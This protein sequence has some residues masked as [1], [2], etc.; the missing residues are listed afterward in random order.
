MP[1]TRSS[2]RLA[3]RTSSQNG[4]SSPPAAKSP[5]NGSTKR[6][7]DSSP[8]SAKAKKG[9]KTDEAGQKTLEETIAGGNQEEEKDQ[10]EDIEMKEAGNPGEGNKPE[11]DNRA[12]LKAMRTPFTHSNLVTALLTMTD[13]GEHPG[14]AGHDGGPSCW[15]WLDNET[16]VKKDEVPDEKIIK[17][18]ESWE[19]TNREGESKEDPEKA[20]KD[21]RGGQ[22]LNTLPVDKPV[23]KDVPN[24]GCIL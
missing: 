13:G 24:V 7:A 22:G 15:F 16:Y 5:T 14:K 20:L 17:A 12:E 23:V 1:S 3:D 8:S 4:E 11:P 10:P 6:K 18:G 21:S 9:R 2:A 19:G